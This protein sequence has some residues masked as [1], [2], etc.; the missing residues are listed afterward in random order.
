MREKGINKILLNIIL[1]FTLI[2]VFSTLV[3][4]EIDV[5]GE[6][7]T[8]AGFTIN[9]DGEIYNYN[10]QEINLDLF[11]PSYGK[12]EP[13]FAIKLFN[14][15][16]TGE[17]DYFIKKLY[18]KHKFDK[19]HISMGRQPV[20][21]SFGS[22]LNPVDYNTGAVVM[23]QTTNSK[24][25][26]GVEVYLPINWNS[27]ITAVVSSPAHSEH[28]QWGL[29]NRFGYKGYDI[30]LNLIHE[31]GKQLAGLIIPTANRIG[32][33]AKGD[34]GLLGIYGA[35]GYY[36]SE[37]MEN[38]TYLLGTDYSYNFNYGSNKLMLQLEYINLEP[39]N[40]KNIIGA[41]IPLTY[42][43]D[44]NKLQFLLVNAGYTLDD[45]SSLSLMGISCIEDSSI[46]LIPAYENQLGDKLDITVRGG[47][48]LGEGNTLFG[49]GEVT[50]GISM[51]QSTVE[52]ELSYPF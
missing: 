27:G 8:S 43:G 15:S 13:K 25:I 17:S 33:A 20:S 7:K 26:D 41:I 39:E 47:L 2:F 30:S 10:R 11:L 35:A 9:T 4:A 23:D 5:G 22:L 14:D 3:S 45:F 44:A 16:L 36:A 31:P 24:F 12:T 21:W 29:R 38:M 51:P 32:I 34:L 42:T 49:P 48:Y 19:F 52:I 40:L 37:N 6:L 46:L 50:Q 28:L 1:L 18:L